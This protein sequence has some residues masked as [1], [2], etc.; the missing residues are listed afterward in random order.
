MRGYSNH[1]E[2]RRQEVQNIPKKKAKGLEYLNEEFIEIVI[3]V[4]KLEMRKDTR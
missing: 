2:I 1:V 4:K 3:E